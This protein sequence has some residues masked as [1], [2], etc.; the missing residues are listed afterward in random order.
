VVWAVAAW[1]TRK[2]RLGALKY[3]SKYLF[4]QNDDDEKAFSG[5]AYNISIPNAGSLPL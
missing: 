4:H 2:E 5:Y 3:S 1:S